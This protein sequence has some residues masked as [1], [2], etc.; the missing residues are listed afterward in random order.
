MAPASQ[1]HPL[2]LPQRALPS[3][4][5]AAPSERAGLDATYKPL[6]RLL[7]DA[8]RDVLCAALSA[9]EPLLDRYARGASAAERAATFGE[10]LCRLFPAEAGPSASNPQLAAPQQSPL[11]NCWRAQRAVFSA[12]ERVPDG[13]P[14]E[15]AR[16]ARR[17]PRILAL[18]CPRH[19]NGSAL[20]SP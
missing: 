8:E 7:S 16:A 10:R 4:V 2:F 6:A 13:F 15:M 5:A 18:L 3:V 9:A 17:A 20:P 11:G 12:W 1:H 19:S 14:P